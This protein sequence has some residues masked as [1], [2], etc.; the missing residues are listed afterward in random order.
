MSEP[1][2]QIVFNEISAREISGLATLQ[3]LDL[4]SKF[5]VTPHDLENLD[6]ER[7]GKL[8]REGR[9]LYRYRFNDLRIYFSVED[10]K[11]LVHRV[12][13]KNSFRD[14]LF[15]GGLKTHDEDEALSGAGGFWELIDEGENSR[16]E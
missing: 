4:L 3:Q 14:F 13:H 10:R 9:S 15:R 1:G 12:L 2:L 6:E 7:F 8:E 5:R 11:V 16:A